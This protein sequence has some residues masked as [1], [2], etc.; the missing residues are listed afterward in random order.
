M[1]M[2]ELYSK[3]GNGRVYRRSEYERYIFPEA[4]LVKTVEFWRRADNSSQL[5]LVVE[6]YLLEYQVARAMLP[7]NVIEVLGAATDGTN[8]MRIY[9]KEADV[10]VEHAVFTAHSWTTPDGDKWF[11]CDCEKCNTHKGFHYERDLEGMSWSIIRKARERGIGLPEEDK[12]DYCLSETEIIFFEVGRIDPDT[13]LRFLSE[14]PD[15]FPQEGE[16][17]DWIERYRYLVENHPE[18]FRF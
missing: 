9:S 16:L 11:N 17:M 10:P 3:G 1:S 8:G 4:D 15:E 13:L 12:T 2:G 6:S 7:K 14:H 18:I 5:E